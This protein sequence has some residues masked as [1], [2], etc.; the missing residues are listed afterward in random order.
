MKRVAS[1]LL[2][3]LAPIL[4]FAQQKPRP[5]ITGIGMVMLGAQNQPKSE[6][7]YRTL[8]KALLPQGLNMCDGCTPLPV[9]TFFP[10]GSNQL[11]GE[12]SKNRLEFIGL[13]TDDAR[14]LREWLQRHNCTVGELQHVMNF[15]SF[16]VSDPEGHQLHFVQTKAK[17]EPDSASDRSQPAD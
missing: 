3:S 12:P 5:R 14:A 2:I 13:E 6:E 7:F 4:A 17:S 16:T 1:F 15:F 8:A 10:I 9:E 11:K